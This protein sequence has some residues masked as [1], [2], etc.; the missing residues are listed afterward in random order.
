MLGDLEFRGH[1]RPATEEFNLVA[2]YN[3]GD[4]TEAE[5]LRT[6]L[7]RTFSGADLQKRHEMLQKSSADLPSASS[8]GNDAG[9]SPVTVPIRVPAP[10]PEVGPKQ[11]EHLSFTDAYG[12]RLVYYLSPWELCKLLLWE[13]LYEPTWYETH[14]M[15]CLTK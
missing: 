10:H 8:N 15:P 9:P 11:K 12:Y 5:F 7:K 13:K 14:R 1:A 4:V 6:F 2:H 3:E